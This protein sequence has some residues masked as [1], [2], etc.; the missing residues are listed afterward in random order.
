MFTRESIL[1]FF[2]D[3]SKDRAALFSER[4][5][6]AVIAFDFTALTS[7]LRSS[8]AAQRLHGDQ[9]ERKIDNLNGEN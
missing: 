5:F 3:S 4:T 8:S 2:H 1:S 6:Y 7:T 9:T